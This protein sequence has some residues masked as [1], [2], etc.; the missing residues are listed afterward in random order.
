MNIKKSGGKEIK[1]YPDPREEEMVEFYLERQQFMDP[2]K[3]YS[4]PINL[5]GYEFEAEFGKRQKLPRSVVN[6]LKE[7]RSAVHTMPNTRRVETALGGEGRPQSEL[8]NNQAELRYINDYNVVEE[9]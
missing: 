6:V 2:A 5:N 7:A 1:H 9:R 4:V 3:R 8:L